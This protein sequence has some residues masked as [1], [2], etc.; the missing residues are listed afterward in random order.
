MDL[1][2]VKIGLTENFDE[3]MKFLDMGDQKVKP[4][5]YPLHS[6]IWKHRKRLVKLFWFVTI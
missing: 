1:T 2:S 5:P 6:I 4:R 3:A